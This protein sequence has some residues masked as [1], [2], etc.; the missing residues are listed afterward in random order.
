M[1]LPAFETTSRVFGSEICNFMAR[2]SEKQKNTCGTFLTV[3]FIGWDSALNVENEKI[4]SLLES[5]EEI[6]FLLLPIANFNFT[7]DLGIYQEGPQVLLL[8]VTAWAR[9]R[10]SMVECYLFNGSRACTGVIS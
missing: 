10:P 5:W 2:L 3:M 4:W 1:L 9:D 6:P 8:N 7:E